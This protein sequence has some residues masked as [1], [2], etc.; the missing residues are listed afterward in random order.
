[1]DLLKPN[2]R[3]YTFNG[4]RSSVLGEKKNLNTLSAN[5][6][7]PLH[8]VLK[9]PSLSLMANCLQTLALSCVEYL[10]KDGDSI[11]V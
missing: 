4:G 2:K 1:M 5:L 10:E 8:F 6:V 7:G 11:G 9:L 3:P